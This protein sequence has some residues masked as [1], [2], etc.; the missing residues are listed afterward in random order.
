[1]F[2]LSFVVIQQA[3]VAVG[4]QLEGTKIKGY[5]AV[6]FVGGAVNRKVGYREFT[7][8]YRFAVQHILGIGQY[9]TQTVGKCFHGFV[10]IHHIGKVERM[11]FQGVVLTVV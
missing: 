1:M 5:N 10:A 8:I 4:F 2:I 6:G 3:E 7:A 9:R 11:V